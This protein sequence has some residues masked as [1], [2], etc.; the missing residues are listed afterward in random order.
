M[1]VNANTLNIK[2]LELVFDHKYPE[3]CYLLVFILF[4]QASLLSPPAFRPSPPLKFILIGETV[5]PCP[6]SPVNVFLFP[7][8][9]PLS[10]PGAE[11]HVPLSPML[12]LPFSDAILGTSLFY[13]FQLSTSV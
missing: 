3:K 9:W 13:L 6:L 1:T 11:G 8:S 12:W 4:L 5:A 2:F 7:S 10:K